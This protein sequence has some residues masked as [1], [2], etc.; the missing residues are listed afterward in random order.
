MRTIGIVLLWVFLWPFLIFYYPL[1]WAW[2]K[3][4][5]SQQPGTTSATVPRKITPTDNKGYWLEIVGESHYRDNFRKICGDPD[6]KGEDVETFAVL[7]FD[8]NNPHDPGNAVRV[9]IDG[10]P[11]GYLP[12]EKAKVWRK[13]FAK[14]KTDEITHVPARIRGGWLRDDGWADYGVKLKLDT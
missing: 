14:L 5:K 13:A 1:R 7:V 8:D 11:V 2:K 3:L 10:L 9:E 4:R 12:R 6:G